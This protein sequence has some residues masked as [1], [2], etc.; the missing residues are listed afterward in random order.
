M[1]TTLPELIEKRAGAPWRHT[2]APTRAGAPTANRNTRTINHDTDDT[3]TAHA[4]RLAALVASTYNTRRPKQIAELVG[5]TP[6]DRALFHAAQELR[7]R[8]WAAR[9]TIGRD[10]PQPRYYLP[11]QLAAHHATTP[12]EKLGPQLAQQ[13]AAIIHHPQDLATY[14]TALRTRHNRPHLAEALGHIAEKIKNEID[15]AAQALKIAPTRRHQVRTYTTNGVKTL[16][17]N[18]A[19]NAAHTAHAHLDDIARAAQR[20]TKQ[21]QRQ[22][23][24][25][26][27]DAHRQEIEQ[28]NNGKPTNDASLTGWYPAI[29]NKPDRE[30]SHT[31]RLGRRRIATNAGKNPNRIHNYAGD[32]HRRIF[33]R[34]TRGTNALVIVDASGSMSLTTDDLTAIMNA[35]AGATVIAYSAADYTTPNTHLLAHKGRKVRHLPRFAG[36]NGNDAPAA[37]YAIAN[38]RKT[39]AP[40]LWITDGRATGNGD[41]TSHELRAQCRRLAQKHGIIIAPDVEQALADLATIKAGKRPP[42][43]LHTFH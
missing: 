30:L 24:T 21:D 10:L 11:E 38:Y 29:M 5:K 18:N 37:A 36:N 28:R 16:R 19:E 42:Q 3:P 15:Y 39:G 27:R 13:L 7:N 14:L 20:A 12:P 43:R 32:P 6:D 35:S 40:V 26:Q 22:Q 23:R 17:L 34:N 31:G 9:T 8:L 41:T 25:K 4:Q 1:K 33:T 2:P